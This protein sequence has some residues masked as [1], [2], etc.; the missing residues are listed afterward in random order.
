MA[1][2]HWVRSQ[3]SIDL[4]KCYYILY[5]IDELYI[6]DVYNYIYINNSILPKDVI[7]LLASIIR[8]FTP[9]LIKNFLLIYFSTL[10][11]D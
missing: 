6:I 9:I 1:V 2:N 5:I 8:L 7:Q 10:L 11:F 3:N 4:S